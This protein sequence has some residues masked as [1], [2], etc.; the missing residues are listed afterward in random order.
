MRVS[1]KNQICHKG[2]Y[3][4]IYNRGNNKQDIFLDD[5][6]YIFYLQRLRQAKEKQKASIICYCLMPNH[7]HLLVKQNSEIPIYRLISSIH[8]SYS[9]YFN[10]KYGKVGHLFQGRFKQNGV[11]KDKYL[12]Q[13]SSYIHLNPLMNGLVNKLKDYQ[14][15]SYPDYIGTRDGTLCQ[16]KTVLLNNTSKE[17]KQITEEQILEKLDEKEFQKRLNFRDSP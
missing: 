7:I 16:K 13:L 3:Y 15:S 17:Y 11:D 10:R 6:D 12:L 1:N 9:M 8:T 2:G 14:W 4:H 5:S